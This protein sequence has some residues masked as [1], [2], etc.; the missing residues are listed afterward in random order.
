MI[1]RNRVAPPFV[2]Q[3]A[4]TGIGAAAIASASTSAPAARRI[5]PA[6]PPP[7]HPPLL[8]G[9]TMA[10]A[11]MSRMLPCTISIFISYAG[12]ALEEAFDFRSS[13]PVRLAPNRFQSL[14]SYAGPALEDA[15]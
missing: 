7:I 4:P 1:P 3:A 9:L 8:A 2:R 15:F 14:Y 5:A 11:S 10:S 12:P 13:P 6:T